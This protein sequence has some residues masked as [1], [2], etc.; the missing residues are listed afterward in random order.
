MKTTANRILG[1]VAAAMIVPGAALA[2]YPERGIEM[3]VAFSPGGGTDVAAR[4]IQPFIEEALGT[5]I[6]V[7]NVP[8]AGGEVG[9]TELATSE[10]DG[11]TIGFINVPAIFAYSYERE[12]RYSRDSF[13]P[14]ANLVY[15]PGIFAVRADSEFETLQDLIQ[16]GVDNPGALPIGTS[17]S[18][19][20]S[21]HLA[22]LN[23]QAQTGASFN[24]APFGSTAPLRTALLGGHIP[25]AAFNLSEAV[26]FEEAGELRVLG[27]MASER[28][29]LS[30]DVPTFAEQGVDIVAGSS[31]GIAAPAGV[32][33][34]IL[35]K[36]S[37]AI[38]EAM[39]AGEYVANAES[40]NIP[41][42]YMDAAEYGA[43]LDNTDAAL[44]EIW[45][46]TPWRE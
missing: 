18:T 12:T 1:A 30:P 2:D 22:I 8:G 7:K 37:A 14:I 36:L 43:F 15:D 26:Q 33:Q 40:A 9:F 41:L 35:D 13:A 10:S 17:G 27:V 45:E 3:I 38:G 4:S 20:S 24:H 44:A 28:S 31:R 34:E 23:V 32:P 29:G 6:T 25:V 21:E 11:Y 5:D 46:T 19:G 39:S 16:Y 42:D